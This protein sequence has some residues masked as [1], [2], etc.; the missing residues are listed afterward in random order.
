MRFRSSIPAKVAPA[1]RRW[2]YAALAA[3]PGLPEELD[4]PDPDPPDPDEL[5]PLDP[6]E[7]DPPAPLDPDELDPPLSL[8]G[9][10]VVDVFS[11]DA[12]SVDGLL[13]VEVLDS[14]S[15][16]AAAGL[17]DAELYRSE[18]QPLPLRMN[19]VPREI[20]RRAVCAWQLGH[21]VMALSLMDC[22]NSHS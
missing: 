1:G 18:Y 6:D 21:S 16:D 20:C 3:E 4:P 5:D 19:P 15:L 22:S 8:D 2:R 17:L 11:V 7:L 14:P 12:L 13:S 10:S 9:L